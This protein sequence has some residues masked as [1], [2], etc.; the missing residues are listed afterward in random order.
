M[1]AV[2]SK[3]FDRP[4]DRPTDRR[5]SVINLHLCRMLENELKDLNA[6]QAASRRSL[7]QQIFETREELMKKRMEKLAFGKEKQESWKR[8]LLGDSFSTVGMGIRRL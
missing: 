2:T 1:T 4:C 5:V 7:S 3:R 8:N 6:K